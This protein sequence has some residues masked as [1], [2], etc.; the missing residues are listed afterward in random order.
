M[1]LFDPEV[2]LSIKAGNVAGRQG[3]G[4]EIMRDNERYSETEKKKT[5]LGNVTWGETREGSPCPRG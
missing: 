3:G 1:M 2:G 5:D 4:R